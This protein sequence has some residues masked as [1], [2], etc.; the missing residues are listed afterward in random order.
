MPSTKQL[1]AGLGALRQADPGFGVLG[2]DSHEYALNPPAT[3][4][5]VREVEGRWGF[6]VPADYRAFLR[7]AGDGGAGPD[8]GLFP[9]G[10][11]TAGGELVDWDGS[12]GD[13]AIA[14]AHTEAWND[15][16]DL[17]ATDPEEDAALQARF[18]HLRPEE[19]W[20]RVMTARR[21]FRAYYFEAGSGAIPIADAGCNLVYLL[22]VTGAEVGHVWFDARADGLG[23][24]PVEAGGRARVTFSEWY[25][26]WLERSL[27]ERAQPGR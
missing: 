3:E 14:F 22:V 9:L 16:A 7:E 6:Q 21:A 4:G 5:R 24:S 11:M 19:R 13:P 23:L 2:A 20:P 17:E 12:I 18:G 8:H 26:D 27:A 10:K 25:I 15:T 1:L